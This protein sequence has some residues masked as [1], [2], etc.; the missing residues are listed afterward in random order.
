MRAVLTNQRDELRS[1]R[2]K[3]SKMYQMKCLN[4]RARA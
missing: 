3:V 4:A 1:L 2:A